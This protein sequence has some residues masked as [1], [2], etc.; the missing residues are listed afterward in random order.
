MNVIQFP[1]K[2]VAV[3]STYNRVL[4]PIIPILR[5]IIWIRK[6]LCKHK[7]SDHQRT[8]TCGGSLVFYRACDKCGMNRHSYW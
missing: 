5:L 6:L 8:F 1:K 2:N 3:V 4:I 7:W